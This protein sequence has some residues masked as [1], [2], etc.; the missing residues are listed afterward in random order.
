MVKSTTG[1][2]NGPAAMGKTTPQDSTASPLA[3]R[4][5]VRLMLAGAI[6]TFIL[7]I[8]GV[9]V[10]LAFRSVAVNYYVQTAH[11]TV[12][13]ATADAN[14]TVLPAVVRTVLFAALWVLMAR[15]NRDGHGWARIV[16]TVLFLLWSYDTY[17]AIEGLKTWFGFGNVIFSLLI[18]GVG[19]GALYYL[20]RPDSTAYFQ[21]SRTSSG[22]A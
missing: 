2:G 18:W 14:G 19:C 3:V 8:F 6:G 20:W 9:L 21:Q 15:L 4:R 1:G 22:R 7:G 12:S 10:T 13:K 17:E 11:V 5:A 16:S